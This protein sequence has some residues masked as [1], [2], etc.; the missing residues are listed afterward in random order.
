LFAA[1]IGLSIG[2]HQ[3]Q[4]E[5]FQFTISALVFGSVVWLG[6]QYRL[7]IF[8]SRIFYWI[9]RLSYGMYLNHE[10][11]GHFIVQVLLA[12][13][14]F[15]ARFPALTCVIGFVVLSLISAAIALVTFCFVEYPFLQIRKN[16]LGKHSSPQASIDS[17]PVPG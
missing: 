12:R 1:S 11:L 13:L 6:I 9:S 3:I 15:A 4:K 7:S 10:Y 14:P 2:L 8:N 5:I 17:P 16:V